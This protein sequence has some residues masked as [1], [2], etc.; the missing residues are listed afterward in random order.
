MVRLGGTPVSPPRW[1]RGPGGGGTPPLY[2]GAYRI[3]TL[4]A[5]ICGHGQ[6]GP[7]TTWMSQYRQA[8][9]SG[10]WSKA[11]GFRRRVEENGPGLDWR[12]GGAHENERLTD[13]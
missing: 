11:S 5:S 13:S 8:D 9:C 3:T 1:E 2:R 6:I 7:R 4:P 12:L 10:K